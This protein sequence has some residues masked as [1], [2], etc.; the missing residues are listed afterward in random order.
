MYGGYDSTFQSD[1]HRYV[2]M[3]N[4]WFTPPSNGTPPG[5]RERH[6]LAWDPVGNALVIFGGQNRPTIMFVHYDTLHVFIADTFTPIPKSGAWPAARKDATLLWIPHLS[7]FLLYGGN[8]GAMANNRF[9]DLWLLTLNAAAGTGSW[10][11]L[12]PTGVAPPAQSAGCVV[13]DPAARRLILYGG[14]T[15]DGVDVSTTYQYLLDTNV[16]QQDTT[17]G[18]PPQGRSFGQCAW[19]PTIGRVLFYGGQFAGGNPI[20]GDAIYDPDA[21]AWSSPPSTG[22]AIGSRADGGAVYSAELGGLLWYGGRTAVTTY[23]SELVIS[24]G[25]A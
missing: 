11:Q 19:D 25:V 16:W 10:Q 4:Q 21:H 6:A 14:E 9:S 22:P 20:G 5:P 18:T 8:D 15:A 7:K 17:T 13:Y 2:P 1:I 12:T 24:E 3:M 23:T